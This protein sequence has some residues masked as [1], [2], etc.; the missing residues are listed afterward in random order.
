M[1]RQLL[2]GNGEEFIIC[3]LH[4]I[5]KFIGAPPHGVIY[6]FYKLRITIY[7]RNE[8]KMKSAW[9]PNRRRLFL[10]Q[11]FKQLQKLPSTKME[12]N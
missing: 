6:K 5:G 3:I 2:K 7:K 11:K 4:P 8:E 9:D 10:G 1:W 12:S